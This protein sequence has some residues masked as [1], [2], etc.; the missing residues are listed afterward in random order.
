MLYIEA[1]M[2]REAIEMYKKA[3]RWADS[4]RVSFT[5]LFFW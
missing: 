5:F 4:Y 3:S 2:H 1:G